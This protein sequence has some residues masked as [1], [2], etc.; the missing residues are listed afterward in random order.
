MGEWMYRS[1]ASC[2]QE[3]SY[4]YTTVVRAA[5]SVREF[6]YHTKP[7]DSVMLDH[8]AQTTYR[9]E[10]S[11]YYTYLPPDVEVKGVK[12]SQCLTN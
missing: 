11:D 10:H 5:A 2:W 8:H 6:Y 9:L 1:T 3:Q 7:V 12:L 4:T